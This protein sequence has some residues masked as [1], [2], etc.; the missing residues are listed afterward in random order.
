M[1]CYR[2]SYSIIEIYIIYLYNK[3]FKALMY[4]YL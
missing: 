1:D 4:T 2:S 3:V